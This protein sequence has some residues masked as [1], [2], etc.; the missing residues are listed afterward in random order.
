MQYNPAAV[1]TRWS[2]VADKV[3]GDVLFLV[4]HPNFSGFDTIEI[5]FRL[6]HALCDLKGNFVAGNTGAFGV[7][8]R[9]GLAEGCQYNHQ[10][11]VAA[12]ID[13]V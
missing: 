9:H 11:V 5:V 6:V 4:C 1:Q 13:T 8:L 7:K 3:L 12:H 10:L 2:Q